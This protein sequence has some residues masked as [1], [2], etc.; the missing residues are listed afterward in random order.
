M[1]KLT[2]NEPQ[3]SR[4]ALIVTFYLLSFVLTYAQEIKGVV[5][6]SNGE[7]IP[8]ASIYIKELTTGTTSNLEGEYSIQLEPGKYT[9]IYQALGFVRVQEEVNLN[10]GILV[11]DIVLHTQDYKIK[12]VRVFGGNE[13][14]AYPIIRKA[15]SLAPYFLRQVKHYQSSVYLKGGFDMNKVPRLFRKK[16]LEEG[17]EEGKSYV[18]ESINEITFDSPNRF[19]HKQ[20]SKHSTIPDDNEQEVMGFINYSF[21]DSDDNIA[22]SP[23]SR[24]A[25]SFYKYQY[26]GFFQQDEYYVNKI[27]VTPKRKNQKLFE[28]YIYVVDDLWNLH[29]VD[30]VNEQFFGKIH[31]KQVQEPV[32][33][34]AWLPVS[35]HF[36]VDVKMMGFNV[37]AN[38]G[39]SVKYTEVILDEGLPVPQSLIDAYN[40]IEEEQQIEQEIAEVVKTKEQQKIEE[41]LAKKELNNREML[42]LSRLME[43]E[44]KDKEREGKGL[45]L[46]SFQDTYKIIKDTVKRDTIDWNKIRP[47]PLS[48]SEIESFGLKDSLTLAKAGVDKDSLKI[49]SLKRKGLSKIGKLLAGSTYY[50]AD[51]AF[52]VRHKGLLS[53]E[54]IEFNAVDGWVFKQE[55]RIRHRFDDKKKRLDLYPE[56]KYSFGRK[57]FMYRLNTYL[58]TDYVKRTRYQ[59]GGG[60]WSADF[61]NSSGISPFVNSVSSLMFKEN[62]MKLYRN[63][64]LNMGVKTDLTNGLIFETGLRYDYARK[65]ENSTNYSMAFQNKSYE[66]NNLPALN[67]NSSAYDSRSAFILSADLT[68]T[69]KYYYRISRGVKRMVES[70]YPTFSLNYKGALINVLNSSSKF[71]LLQAGVK[72]DLEWSY[73]YKFKYN[74]KAGY[75]I[76]HDAMHFSNY[77]HFDTNEPDVSFKDWTSSF[78]TLNNYDYSTNQWFLESHAAFTTPYL[79]IKNVPFLQDKLW[80]EDLYWHHLTTPDLRNYNE[81]GYSVSQIWLLMNVGVFAG[82]EDFKYST[83]GVKVSLKLGEL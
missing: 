8:F 81:V 48:K 39:G 22:I 20:I 28:G 29:S 21:Y 2:S 57:S 46:D 27:K 77:A 31:V 35:H 67:S 53:P 64:Y 32:K 71:H 56:M 47:I 73:M 10:S 52:E 44:N 26:E 1:R 16:L 17:I 25:L 9:I 68:Y 33:G 37:E 13:D 7:S 45:Q 65:L 78:S 43:K 49:D 19:T 15:I 69:P 38:Y 79:L 75:F 12:E 50:V 60:S 30:L 36:D 70:D 23:L 41:L 66:A 11:K 3:L 14:P 54:A 51:S 62:Y 83:W 74:I 58:Y 72:Q 59:L 61:N 18:V 6:S 82:F 40:K 5:R 4:I 76:N 63:D 80:N 42:K 55:F 24:K 34:K